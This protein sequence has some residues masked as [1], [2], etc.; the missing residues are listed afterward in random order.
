MKNIQFFA[1]EVSNRKLLYLFIH[2]RYN[3]NRRLSFLCQIWDIGVP[4]FGYDKVPLIGH[5][6]DMLREE[7]ENR[8]N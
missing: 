3:T 6:D 8:G 4:E 5:E 1:S 2:C 7:Y